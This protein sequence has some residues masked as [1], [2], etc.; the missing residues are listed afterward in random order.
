L[1]SLL[2]TN[3]GFNLNGK[4][5][6]FEDLDEY[7]YHFDRMIIALKNAG[8]FEG[9][10]A[11]IVGGITNMKDNEIPFGKSIEEIILEHTAQYNF[12]IYFGA[13]FG[14][15]DDNYPLILGANI[16]IDCHEKEIEL[17]YI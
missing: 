2:G 8:K 14:H 13:P 9:L 15:F 12:P 17:R 10:K 1:Y 11:I 16:A 7:M 6:F 4:I 3:N 5:L